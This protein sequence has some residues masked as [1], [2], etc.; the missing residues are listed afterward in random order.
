M[1]IGE[2]WLLKITTFELNLIPGYYDLL[3]LPLVALLHL[4]QLQLAY[5]LAMVPF[6]IH[7]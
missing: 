7:I 2:R 1:Y 3:L 5:D 6:I 4:C